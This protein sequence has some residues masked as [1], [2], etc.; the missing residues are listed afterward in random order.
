MERE[1]A[2]ISAEEIIVAVAATFPSPPPIWLRGVINAFVHLP[3]R[4]LGRILT[5]FDAEIHRVGLGVAASRFMTTMGARVQVHGSPPT[6]SALVVMNHPGAYDALAL[7]SALGRDDVRFLAKDRRFLRVLPHLSSRMIFVSARGLR[8]ALR[9]LSSNGVVVQ[10]GA[11][12]IEPDSRFDRGDLSEWPE[13]TGFLASR[14]RQVVPAFVSGVHSPRAKRLP[15]VK[16]A[17]SRGITTIG[18]L[19][20][21]TMPGFR[22]VNVTL[23]F[24]S[25][26]ESVA[27]TRA[28]R[29]REVREAVRALRSPE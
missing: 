8:E 4:R 24:G 7:M 17:E 22:D 18:P 2:R 10:L 14:A 3:S 29:T 13:G 25:A 6:G 15:I 9:H 28:A 23:R 5:R 27:S 16:W 19:I 11:G 12:A 21:A 1:I 26:I 20:Q